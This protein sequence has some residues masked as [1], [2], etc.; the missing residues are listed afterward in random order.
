MA[1]VKFICKT[2]NKKNHE[3]IK[4]KVYMAGGALLREKIYRDTS[5]T[6]E[7]EME[8]ISEGGTLYRDVK[9]NGLSI[10]ANIVN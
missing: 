7:S 1:A 5:T 4:G 10:S 8:I 6:F 3:A 2:N 9:E